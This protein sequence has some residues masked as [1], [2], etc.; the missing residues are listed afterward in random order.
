MNEKIDDHPTLR[1]VKK[2]A[3]QL[4]NFLE[5]Y[6]MDTK[7]QNGISLENLSNLPKNSVV[8]PGKKIL[9]IMFNKAGLGYLCLPSA[10][11]KSKNLWQ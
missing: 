8:F 5:E 6:K 9:D 7:K 3:T 11:D 1:E 4:L 2:I 10:I